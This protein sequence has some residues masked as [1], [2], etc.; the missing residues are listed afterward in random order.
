MIGQVVHQPPTGQRE[1]EK[2]FK[3]GEDWGLTTPPWIF[4]N[5]LDIRLGTLIRIVVFSSYIRSDRY[6]NGFATRASCV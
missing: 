2:S 4:E 5:L 1:L 3:V 6:H